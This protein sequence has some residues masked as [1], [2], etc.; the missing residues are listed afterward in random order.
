MIAGNPLFLRD[1]ELDRSV[2]LL[3]LAERDVAGQMET[4]RQRLGLS[5][6]DYRVLYLVHR[7]PGVTTAELGAVLGMTKQSLS[8][9]VKQLVALDLLR[10]RPAPTAASGRCTPPTAPARQSRRS[11]RSTSAV[12]SVPSRRPDRRRS[13]ASSAFSAS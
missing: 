7:H 3:L 4:V 6:S 12:S 9:H 8:R 13:R 10:R 5:E 2:E 1:E 11:A